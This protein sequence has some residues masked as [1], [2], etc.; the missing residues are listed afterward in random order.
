MQQ[1]SLKKHQTYDSKCIHN[2]LSSYKILQNLSL[3]L[4]NALSSYLQDTLKLHQKQCSESCSYRQLT[5]N[6]IIEIQTYDSKC[7]HN[8]LSSYRIL[9]N[10][11][12]FL[13]NAL[14]SYLQDTLKLHQK[15]CSESCSYRQLTPNNIIEIQTYDSKCI[16]NALSSYRISPRYTE[17]ASEAMLRK[18]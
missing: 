14:S 17:I 18:L 6:N 15:Q 11:S 1:T 5:P 16:H 3:F 9:Q 13:Q 8:A 7:I 2:A 12:L 4:Q 10:L